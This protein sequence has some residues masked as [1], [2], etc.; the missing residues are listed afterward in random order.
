MLYIELLSHCSCKYNSELLFDCSFLCLS[1]DKLSR[2]CLRNVVLPSVNVLRISS[3]SPASNFL[4][5]VILSSCHY[6]C[7]MNGH[8]AAYDAAQLTSIAL[9][10]FFHEPLLAVSNLSVALLI[11]ISLY[12]GH[13]F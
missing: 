8:I 13:L 7:V 10:G 12:L 5:I 4:L 9:D 6:A 11:A 2:W 1:F 3:Q